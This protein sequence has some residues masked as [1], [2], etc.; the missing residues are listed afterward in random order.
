M[1]TKKRVLPALV[2]SLFAATAAGSASAQQFSQTVV[3]G[4]SLSDAG[5]YRPFLTALGLPAP[6][7]SQLGRFTTSPGPVWS[8]LI[9][10]YYGGTPAPSNAGGNIFAQG[11][12]RVAVDSSSTPPGNAQRPVS[13]QITEFLAR[14]NG[15]A[16][17]NALYAIWAGANDVIQ[18][19][20]GAGAGTIPQSQLPTII[21]NTANAE[22]AQIARLQAAGARYIIV[23]GLPN[24][25]GTPAFQAAGTATATGA[26]Q[27][28][29][30]FNT[31]LFTGLAASGIHVI[32]VDAGAFLADVVANPSRDGFTNITVPA[33]GAFPPF[34]SG[35]DALFCPPNVQATNGAQTYLFADGIHP[36]TAAHAEIAQFI[37]GMIT[38]PAEYSLLAEVPLRSRQGH[39]RSVFEGLAGT[40]NDSVGR[41]SIWATA[42]KGNF[43]VDTSMGV[44]GLD[45]SNK[46]GTI[47][48]SA[49]V[50]EGVSI[51]VAVG[52]TTADA[53]FGGNNGAFRTN[54]T[55]FSAYAQARWGG[56]YADG[57]VS[58]AN[59]DFS[60]VS[61]NIPIGP[62]VRVATADPSGSNASAYFDLGYDFRIDRFTVGPLVS[63]TSQNVDI[64]AFDESGADSSNLH[65]GSQSRKSE[66]WSVGAKASL[67]MGSWSPWIRITADKERK[68]DLRFVTA[69]PLS[70]ASNNSYSIP[71]YSFDTSFVTGAV[72]VRGHIERIG[73]SLAY[74]KVSGRSGIKEDGVT[75]MLSYKF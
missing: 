62:T 64:N 41:W 45:S 21:T 67:D 28:S 46:S 14:S 40:A 75:G 32:P 15:V 39:V 9:T 10:T 23:V 42:D 72:G 49:R 19:L 34:S 11:G 74:Y 57:I 58:I 60:N 24:I 48:V 27:L 71:A 56:L 31:A 68:D 16:D 51:G 47:G 13:T 63:V 65:I 37:E 22:I 69:M 7:V 53:T 8:E 29:A 43:D 33:C 26:A 25:G 36:T 12:A 20:Q 59:L 70:L 18:S 55:V 6:L 44:V 50:S 17:P 3:F 61:R 38:G 1:T 52:K 5:Y 2:F 73:L 30:G 66:V 54:E 4:D 35:P